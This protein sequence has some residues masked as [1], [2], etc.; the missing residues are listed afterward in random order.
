MLVEKGTFLDRAL[1]FMQLYGMEVLETTALK[2]H[3]NS[4]NEA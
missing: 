2:L 1:R 4:I 3:T